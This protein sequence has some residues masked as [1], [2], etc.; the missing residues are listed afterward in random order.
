MLNGTHVTSH[1]QGTK[2]SL[3]RHFSVP[4]T[5]TLQTKFLE[6]SSSVTKHIQ[7]LTNDLLT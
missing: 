4:I 3:G 2:A 6:A 1:G 7:E 5:E